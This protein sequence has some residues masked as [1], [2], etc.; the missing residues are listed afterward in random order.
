M[1]G[2]EPLRIRIRPSPFASPV[3]TALW[4]P[5]GS[6]RALVVRFNRQNGKKPDQEVKNM[7]RRVDYLAE[8]GAQLLARRIERF[9]A[10]KGKKVS[11]WVEHSTGPESGRH[12]AVRSDLLNGTPA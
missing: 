11:C 7:S 3:P 4:R 1:G 10:A 2:A 12:F 6:L 5:G 8:E 9:W